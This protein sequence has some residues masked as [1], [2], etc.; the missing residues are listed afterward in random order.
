MRDTQQ[1]VRAL[2]GPLDIEI[3]EGYRDTAVIGRSLGDYARDWAERARAALSQPDQET[4]LSSV[5]RA[6]SGYRTADRDARRAS[7]D[8]A[9]ELL[10]ELEEA[11]RPAEQRAR[12]PARAGAALKGAARTRARSPSGR[13]SG[14]SPAA[15][16]APAPVDSADEDHASTPYLDEPLAQGRY[17]S[18]AWIQR[19]GKLGIETRR[20]LL[21]HV[22]RDYVLVKCIADLH[23]GER[24][25]VVAEAGARDQ[26]VTREGRS[27]RLMRCALEIRDGSGKAWVTSFARVPRHGRRSKAILASPLALNY[28]E[29]TRLLVEGTIRRA[30]PHIEIQYS[31][32]QKL[33][34][35]E[36]ITP[37]TLAPVYPLTDGVYQGQL[38]PTVRRILDEMP[39]DTP[40]PLPESLR[41]RHNLLGLPEALRAI[42][43]PAEADEAEKARRRLVF[44]ELLT[45]QLAL[46][47]RKAAMQRPGAGLSMKPRGDMVAVL[48]EIL[49]FTL[50]RAQQRVISEIAADMAADQPMSRL[51]QGDVG[52]G[53]TVIAAAA[54]LIALQS[55]YQGALMAPTE[56]LAEQHYLVLSKMLAALGVRLQLLTG[57]LRGQEK[58]SAADR[59]ASGQAQVVVGTHALIQEGVSFSNLGLV[60]VDE[61]HRFGVGQRAELR[62]KGKQPDMLVMTATPIPRTRAMTLYGDLDMSVLDEMP[63]S[64]RP[65]RTRWMPLEQQGEAYEFVRQQTAEGRQTYIVCPLVEESEKLQ[66]EAATKLAE[67]L[68]RDVFPD[69]QIGLLHGAMPVAEKD[70]TMESFRAGEKSILCATTVIEVG[71]DVPNA[72]VMLVLNAER[73][74]L[75]QLHQ[76]RGRVGRGGQESHCILLTD[77]KYNPSPRLMPAGDESLGQARSRLRVL[78]DTTDGFAIAEQDLLL[79]GPGEFYGR[80]QH[81]A[82]ELRLARL[83]RDVGTLEEARTAAFRLIEQHPDLARSEHATLRRQVAELRA[84][85]E[86]AVG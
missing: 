44:E 10:S 3:R 40:D 41:R 54:L 22:P 18:V 29:G 37:G 70:V 4:I 60:I 28:P 14:T 61:Q 52:S 77:R 11:L 23:D 30:G 16:G 31:G 36:D 39:A 84:R 27:F 82:P 80:R 9:Q 24:A 72:T 85:V 74:G 12:R 71:V 58:Q 57:S 73:F 86:Q 66:A 47:Q 2:A 59:I 17:R 69:L 33:V 8:E 56:L 42:H 63:P 45:L 25:A 83:A 43:W 1:I 67:E 75:A 68:G 6:L 64:R 7:V 5:E 20:D 65:V 19:L 79:R 51:L 46:A 76:L 13:R 32:S 50:T 55:G 81:G 15:A 53:K 78:L 35:G 21:Y 62:T 26:A 38:R 34:P 48:E 49:P